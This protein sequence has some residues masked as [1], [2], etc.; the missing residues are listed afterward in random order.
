MMNQKYGTLNFKTSIIFF[1]VTKLHGECI[2]NVIHVHSPEVNVYEIHR[3]KALRN[4]FY[5][6]LLS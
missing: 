1:E 5:F 3:N 6:F 4:T 2:K